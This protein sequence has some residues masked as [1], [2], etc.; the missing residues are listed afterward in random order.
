MITIVAM[1]ATIDS[2]YQL[3]EVSL[4]KLI[5]LNIFVIMG[6]VKRS[7]LLAFYIIFEIAAIPIF[8]II[9]G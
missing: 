9:I 4:V 6:L 1:A 5:N 3:R 2:R 8:L 7:S